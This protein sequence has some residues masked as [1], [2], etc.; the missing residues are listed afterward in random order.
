MEEFKIL[1]LIHNN[2]HTYGFGKSIS[3]AKAAAKK[4]LEDGF[5]FSTNNHR[6]WLGLFVKLVTF[7]ILQSSF[8]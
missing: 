8:F 3:E 6:I 7:D 1:V 4:H 5:R 2:K